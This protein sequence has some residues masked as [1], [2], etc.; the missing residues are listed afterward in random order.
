MPPESARSRLLVAAPGLLDPNFA[1]TVLLV[2]EHTPEGALGVVLNR[3]SDTPVGAVLE[4]WSDVVSEPG[5]FYSGG[6]VA[7]ESL[8]ALVRGP[9]VDAQGWVPLFDGLGSIDLA[10]TPADTPPLDELRIFAGH[11]GWSPGQLDAE[12]AAGGW[13]T[14]DAAP[15]DAF[16]RAPEELWHSVL[17]RQPGRLA[18]FAN[19][20]LDP[21]TN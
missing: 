19:A 7:S 11:A 16:T 10:D 8:I 6:P 20:P 18:W 12:L 17:A 9:A 15:L 1:R 14:V 4:R 13:L 5:V 21:S 2:L 3:P